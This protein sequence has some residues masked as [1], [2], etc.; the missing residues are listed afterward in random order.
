MLDPASDRRHRRHINRHMGGGQL[1]SSL[2]FDQFSLLRTLWRARSKG[3][4]HSKSMPIAPP[5][6]H[7]G[8]GNLLPVL[9]ISWLED[10]KCRLQ[11]VATYELHS[12]HGYIGLKNSH[13][14]LAPNTSGEEKDVSHHH[15]HRYLKCGHLRLLLLV[16]RSRH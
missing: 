14:L 15:H 16:M 13:T 7:C 6:M 4:T 10:Q 8:S 11:I 5:A 12:S 2:L 3:H 9:F 1:A